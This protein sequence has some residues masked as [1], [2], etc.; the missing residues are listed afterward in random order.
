MSA[1]RHDPDILC[2]AFVPAPTGLVD[3]HETA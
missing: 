2:E 3:E 1:N